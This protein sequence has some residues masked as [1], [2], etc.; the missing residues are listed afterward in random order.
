[1][2]RSESSPLFSCCFLRS[3]LSSLPPSSVFHKGRV[4]MRD[5]RREVCRRVWSKQNSPKATPTPHE[6]DPWE[7]N[8]R[9]ILLYDIKRTIS[10]AITKWRVHYHHN[11]Q[12]NTGILLMF[13][14][15][16]S[17]SSHS[18]ESLHK[19]NCENNHVNAWSYSSITHT[20]NSALTLADMSEDCP[21]IKVTIHVSWITVFGKKNQIKQNINP[22][23]LPSGNLRVW[24]WG[25]FRGKR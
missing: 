24:W 22:F 10:Q 6:R 11:R 20:E 23:Q 7:N 3:S 21:T 5:W 9:R 15:S 19:L 13:S 2:P 8:F 17:L 18:Y 25:R 12:D 14:M 16:I 1:M 4:D